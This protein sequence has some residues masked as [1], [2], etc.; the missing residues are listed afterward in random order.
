[1]TEELE[2][3]IENAI[4]HMKAFVDCGATPDC[5]EAE[6][7][8]ILYRALIRERSL[9]EKAEKAFD[10]LNAIASVTREWL[11]LCR[12]TLQ[13]MPEKGLITECLD[14]TGT[15]LEIY[16]RAMTLLAENEKLRA[17]LLA[18]RE[19]KQ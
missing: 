16:P 12:H 3:Q 2:K 14:K 1:M 11:D 15:V 5:H 13:Q 18:E 9:R 7:A 6:C 4:N 19:K 8:V 10:D 17:M